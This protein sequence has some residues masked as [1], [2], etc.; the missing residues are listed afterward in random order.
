MG[1]IIMFKS[2][3]AL[4]LLGEIQAIHVAVDG[5]SLIPVYS[6]KKVKVGEVGDHRWDRNNGVISGVYDQSHKGSSTYT[7]V[8]DP[9]KITPPAENKDAAAKKEEKPAAKEEKKEEK[10]EEAK[11]EAKKEEKPAAKEEKK[12]AKA[13]E[14]KAEEK[15]AAPAKE[16]K[17]T[18]E[19]PAAKEKAEAEAA[20]P[21]DKTPKK[22]EAEAKKDAAPAKEEA[23][24]PTEKAAIQIAA[25][26]DFAS[27]FGLRFHQLPSPVRY[28]KY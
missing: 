5:D 23:A 25:T 27:R 7:D 16:E 17:K 18:K 2:L 20:A 9:E 12:E 22:K 1:I 15:E 19:S 26:E 13:A 24:A 21:E 28:H 8:V 6:S 14:P 10:K 11:E 4:L 3:A